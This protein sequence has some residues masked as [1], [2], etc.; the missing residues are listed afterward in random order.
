MTVR[1]YALQLAL[2]LAMVT[3]AEAQE[4]APPQAASPPAAGQPPATPAPKAAEP[5][6]PAAGDQLPEVEV[7]Q[8]KQPV[9]QKAA[10]KKAVTKQA[11]SPAAAPATA[12][13]PTDSAEAT[14]GDNIQMSPLAGSEIPRD[15]VPSGIFT[16]SPSDI[17]REG[18]GQIPQIL[19]QNVPGHHHF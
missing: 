2:L 7:I 3:A 16:V 13:E 10:P 1:Q 11:P 15:K 8:K 14:I 6:P 4:P 9:A 18:L 17:S 19:Q 5:A 12:P